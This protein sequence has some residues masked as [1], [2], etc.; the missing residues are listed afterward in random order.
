MKV[1]DIMKYLVIIMALVLIAPAITKASQLDLSVSMP[2]SM[3]GLHSQDGWFRFQAAYGDAEYTFLSYE[4]F[5]MI[6]NDVWAVHELNLF[7]LGIGGRVPLT[8]K[9]NFF[10]QVGYYLIDSNPDG[11]HT[12]NEGL[13]YYL[14]RKF[15]GSINSGHHYEA[16]EVDA[17]DGTI[18]GEIGLNYSYTKNLSFFTSL[19]VMRIDVL[20]RGIINV[21]Q[22]EATGACWETENDINLTTIEFG[23]KWAFRGL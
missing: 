20:Y 11:R 5:V 18:A 15:A 4:K 14:N 6:P 8:Q 7:G 12:E 10:G 23:I 13:G 2:Q 3:E 16:Y 1:I 9:L 21:A 17:D 19:R 22:Y